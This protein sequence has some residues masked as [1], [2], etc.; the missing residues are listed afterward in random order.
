MP[1]FLPSHLFTR[2][3]SGGLTFLL[4]TFLPSYF[5]KYLCL[6]VFIRGFP[7]PLS[8]FIFPISGLNVLV[9]GA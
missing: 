7:Y 8:S 4:F 1:T 2:R 3:L 9:F 6:F 5:S